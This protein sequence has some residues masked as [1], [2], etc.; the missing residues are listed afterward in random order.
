MNET[1]SPQNFLCPSLSQSIAAPAVAPEH[2]LSV[3]K[4]HGCTISAICLISFSFFFSFHRS[5]LAD[6]HPTH[7]LTFSLFKLRDV[8]K[9][10]GK[11]SGIGGGRDWRDTKYLF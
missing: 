9:Y 3:H 1:P 7:R 2:I 10:R 5:V 6:Y 8:D 4:R 11:F